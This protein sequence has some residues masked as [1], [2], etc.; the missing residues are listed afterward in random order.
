MLFRSSALRTLPALR[1]PHA[2]RW[3]VVSNA[4]VALNRVST[5][6]ESREEE[7]DLPPRRAN[8][9]PRR[10]VRELR[11]S[12]GRRGRVAFVR[13]R[14]RN[15]SENKKRVSVNGKGP[16]RANLPLGPQP[17]QSPSTSRPR[18]QPPSSNDPPRPPFHRGVRPDRDDR[19]A[20]PE[21]SRTEVLRQ[22]PPAPPARPL[23]LGL[24]ALR[25]RS[26]TSAR[27]VH[28]RLPRRPSKV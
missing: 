1:V 27:R 19:R 5:R 18:V 10:A 26:A 22:P 6:K 20:Q 16:V 24:R 12:S 8:E 28:P 11:A 13:S 7:S 2:S 4:A 17:R 9:R 14:V 3:L 25:L 21:C 15:R 23:R